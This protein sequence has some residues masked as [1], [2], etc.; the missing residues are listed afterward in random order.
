LRCDPFRAPV[1]LFE[2]TA[3]AAGSSGRSGAILRQF[4]SDAP[5]AL[6]ARDALRE[7]AGFSAATGRPIGFQRQGV[8]TVAGPRDAEARALVERNTA[9][10]RSLG[11]DARQV[12]AAEMRALAHGIAVADGSLGCFEPDGG[13]VDPVRTVEAFAALAREA[14]ATTSIGRAVRAIETGSGTVRGV[15]T[16]QGLLEA[17]RVIVAA[18]PWSRPLLVAAGIDLPLEVVRPAQQFLTLPRS[19]GTPSGPGADIV[20]EAVLER[21]GIG[22]ERLPPAPHPVVLDLEHGYYTRCE[23]HAGRTRVG[24]LDHARDRSVPDP[25]QV[26][27][28][29]DPAFTRWAHAALARRLPEYASASEAGTGVGLYTLTPDSQAAIGPT[30][31]AGLYVVT[32]FSGHGFKLAPQVGEGVAQLVCGE[33]V[34]AFDEEFFAPARFERAGAKSAGRS[35]GL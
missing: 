12:D 1:L 8:L 24:A 35:F 10:L 19:P 14:G 13:G 28:D 27:E 25:D 7:Y 22:S 31:V 29:V 2:K 21:F 6:M 23:L 11:I 9:L 32:G 33:P 20:A 15:R 18:G 5:L 16:D 17:Q 26:S 34:R 3:L 4:Y 30:R